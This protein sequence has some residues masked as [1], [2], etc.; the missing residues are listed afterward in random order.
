MSY[1]D[2]D[3]SDAELKRRAAERANPK[4]EQPKGILS[5]PWFGFFVIVFLLWFMIVGCGMMLDEIFP[6]R[7]DLRNAPP[8]PYETERDKMPWHP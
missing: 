8:A 7:K 6:K 1:D 5:N 4:K 3:D 2:D